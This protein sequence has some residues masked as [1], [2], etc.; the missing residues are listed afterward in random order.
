MHYWIA[1]NAHDILQLNSLSENGNAWMM[2]TSFEIDKN[3]KK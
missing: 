3:G 1:N 2:L